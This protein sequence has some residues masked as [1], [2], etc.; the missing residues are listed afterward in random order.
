V[1]DA[2]GVITAVVTTS[3]AVPENQKLMELVDQHE[4]NTGQPVQTTVGDHK[5]GTADNFVACHEQGIV[6]HLGDAKAKQAT[7]SAGCSPKKTL[8]VTLPATLTL[9]HRTGT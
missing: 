9:V 3:G 2:Q 8:P 4:Q 5:Y 7:A 6:T 1:D